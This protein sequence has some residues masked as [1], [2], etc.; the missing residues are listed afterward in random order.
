MTNSEIRARLERMKNIA[1]RKR[2]DGSAGWQDMDW[3][4]EAIETLLAREAAVK[5]VFCGSK[6]LPFCRYCDEYKD[7]TGHECMH[8]F[9]ALDESSLMLCKIYAILY[10]QPAALAEEKT[11]GPE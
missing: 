7:Q 6:P 11:N 1:N 2:F 5:A 10:P 3:A 4:V 9:C 8:C